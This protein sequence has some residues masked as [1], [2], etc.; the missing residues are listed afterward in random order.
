MKAVNCK[1]IESV[2]C[3][4]QLGYSAA[5]WVGMKFSEFALVP[6]KASF[7]IESAFD[8]MG[9]W[10]AISPT[11]IQGV[12]WSKLEPLK[13]KMPGTDLPENSPHQIVE[14]QLMTV[15][16]YD[17]VINEGLFALYREIAGRLGKQ[18]EKE[19]ISDVYRSFSKINYYWQNEKK[20]PLFRGGI[21]KIPYNFFSASRS[22]TEFSKDLYR[23][24]KKIIEAS[25]AAI[26]ESIEIG[27]L[28]GNLMN[29]KFIFLMG[30]RAS[31]TFLSEKMFKTFFF[32]YLKKAVE[33]LVQDGFIPR[34]HFG[35]DWTPFLNYF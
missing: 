16:D 15:K 30:A 6:E 4:F 13:V 24:P 23:R 20:V 5:N 33:D 27:K 34:L 2:P 22:L 18:F 35:G 29:S 1:S 11:W 25:D 14:E 21:V 17:L 7:A 12:R 3:A 19:T 31:S 8:K 32:P 9:G 28:I 26:Q 10:D